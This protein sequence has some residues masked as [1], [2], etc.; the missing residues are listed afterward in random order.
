MC[1][2]NLPGN[3]VADS[4]LK[5]FRALGKGFIPSRFSGFRTWDGFSKS[6]FPIPKPEACGT[7][8]VEKYVGLNV[9]LVS[10]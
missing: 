8:F 4:S 10:L 5:R 1:G 2:C 3:T 7:G 9:Q 6:E